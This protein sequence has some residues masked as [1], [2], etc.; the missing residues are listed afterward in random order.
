M[1]Y[2]YWGVLSSPPPVLSGINNPKKDV[3]AISYTV[4]FSKSRYEVTRCESEHF[5]Y[6]VWTC[7]Q[8]FF[9]LIEAEGRFRVLKSHI[10]NGLSACKGEMWLK[11]APNNVETAF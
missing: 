1:W 8:T 4:S 3:H 11:K 5:Y 10:E 6:S 7:M 9:L 2:M